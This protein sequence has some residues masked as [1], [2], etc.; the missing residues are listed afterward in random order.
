MG[1]MDVVDVSE[2]VNLTGARDREVGG[3][4]LILG[5]DGIATPLRVDG[6]V[7]SARYVLVH[8][9]DFRRGFI[10]LAVP[11]EGRAN[12]EA[13]EGRMD[14]VKDLVVSIG[15]PILLIFKDTLEAQRNSLKQVSLKL[16]RD[17]R[18]R[19]INLSN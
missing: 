16:G 7:G 13:V 15:V 12:A 1:R 17:E 14:S 19:L 10:G 11:Y 3:E 5:R 6:E 8:G 18:T 4:P 2:A 9:D